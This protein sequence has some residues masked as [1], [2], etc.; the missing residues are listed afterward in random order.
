MKTVIKAMITCD[1]ARKI[2]CLLVVGLVI[3]D[4]ILLVIINTSPASYMQ[5]V[6]KGVWILFLS[7]LEN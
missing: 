6:A 4:V 2:N 3:V 5:L 7:F 1:I